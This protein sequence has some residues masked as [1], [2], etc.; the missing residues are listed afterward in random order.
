MLGGH[1]EDVSNILEGRV[2]TLE[3]L[4]VGVVDKYI[5]HTSPSREKYIKEMKDLMKVHSKLLETVKVCSYIGKATPEVLQWE[6]HK[7]KAREIYLKQS[8][9]P[10]SE[11]LGKLKSE[12]IELGVYDD[13]L[14]KNY[15]Y[16]VDS[17]GI[18]HSLA[19]RGIQEY[20][21]ATGEQKIT[22]SIYNQGGIRGMQNYLSRY[23]RVTRLRERRGING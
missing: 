22:Q 18:N 2:Y 16:I 13:I 5:T 20:K 9:Y 4:K 7:V 3:E 17:K 12:D 23:Y 11:V 14:S 19:I 15:A 21:I 8:V 6:L 10:P 1:L